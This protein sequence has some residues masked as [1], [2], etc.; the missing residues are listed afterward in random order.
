[1]WEAI[2]SLVAF[3]GSIMLVCIVKEWWYDHTKTDEEKERDHRLSMLESGL[4]DINDLARDD[5][6]K[7]LSNRAGERIE[8][9]LD[10]MFPETANNPANRGK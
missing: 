9:E 8:E 2:I 5:M 4:W 3:F 7:I 1:M 6:R 10:E